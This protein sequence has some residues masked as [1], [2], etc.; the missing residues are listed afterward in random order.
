ME[1]DIDGRFNQENLTKKEMNY[2]IY[3]SNSPIDLSFIYN[4]TS[5]EAFSSYSDDSKAL[6]T[7]IDYKLNDN[8]KFSSYANIDLKNEY[9]PFETSFSLS[10]FDECSE[11]DINYKNTKY[12]DNFATTPEETISFS[13]KMDYLGFFGYEQKSSLFFKETGQFNY[14]LSN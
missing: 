9:S 11:L 5:K 2:S 10:I 14:G 1:F 4:E 12:S 3:F 6:K 7:Q 8:L 13:F